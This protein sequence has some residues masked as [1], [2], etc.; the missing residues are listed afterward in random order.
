[1]ATI[2]DTTEFKT[3]IDSHYMLSVSGLS[4]PTVTLQFEDE[5]G[6]VTMLDADN[7]EITGTGN[8]QGRF[9]APTSNMRLLVASP[10]SDFQF[11]CR[12]TKLATQ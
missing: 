4:G 1:M 8:I 5:G 7:A 6:W 9:Y 3:T 2:S 12:P 11:N 10:G